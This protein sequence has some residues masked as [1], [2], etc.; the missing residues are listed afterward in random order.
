VEAQNDIYM[1]CKDSADFKNLNVYDSLVS[2]RVARGFAQRNAM[3]VCRFLMH[4][5][6]MERYLAMSEEGIKAMLGNFEKGELLFESKAL[7]M[8]QAV[9][10]ACEKD[11]SYILSADISSVGSQLSQN[12]AIFYANGEYRTSFTVAGSNGS[13]TENAKQIV[14]T[15]GENRITVKYP[16]GALAIAGIRIFSVK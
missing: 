4:S 5:T 16:Q 1:C 12:T 11:G 7:S 8:E 6:A 2:G 15:A 13:T 14:L 10:F 9:V 3:N